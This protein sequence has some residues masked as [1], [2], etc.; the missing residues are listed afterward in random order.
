MAAVQLRVKVEQVIA[1]ATNP[2]GAVGGTF[3]NVI[4][5]NAVLSNDIFPDASFA[6]KV[7][8]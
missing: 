7:I 5:V 6:F 4:T 2:V 1:V 3:S 8:L